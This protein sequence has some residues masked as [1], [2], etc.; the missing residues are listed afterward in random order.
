VTP[1]TF[2]DRLTYSQALILSFSEL[3][4]RLQEIDAPSE[5]LRRDY[6]M[7]QREFTS[8]PYSIQARAIAW[9]RGYTGD[10]AEYDRRVK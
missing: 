6:I 10:G 4:V 9:I 1:T 7:A 8:L 2:T 3:S 5:E